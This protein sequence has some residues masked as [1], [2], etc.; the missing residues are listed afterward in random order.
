[1]KILFVSEYF[2]PKLAGGEVWSYELCKELIKK[3][4][5]ITVVTSK[6]DSNLKEEEITD[7]I[8]ILRIASTGRVIK[9]ILF[10]IKLYYLLN[11]LLKKERFDVIHTTSFIANI[12]ASWNARRYKV[13]SVTSV[14]S[15]F[16]KDWFKFENPFKASINFFMERIILKLDKSNVVHVPSKWLAGLVKKIKSNVKVIPNFI[17]K[18]NMNKLNET[19]MIKIKTELEIKPD[20]KLLIFIGSL[21]KIKNILNLVKIIEIPEGFH[22]LIVGEGPLKEKI[23]EVIKKKKI[24][25]KVILLKSKDHFSTM[26]YLQASSVLI[27]PSLSESFGLVVLEALYFNKIIISTDVGIVKELNGDKIIKIN[28]LEEINE[29]L[30][31]NIKKSKTEQFEETFLVKNVIEKFE[32]I[33]T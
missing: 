22:L 24:E 9:R 30:R 5:D 12:P 29:L 20:T 7:G 28:S 2:Y 10:M 13:H 19:E 8:K 27:N 18:E 33:Y 26:K 3:G 11:K 23:I 21:T 15:F 25:D 1:M 16:G 32:N 6:Y 17:V 14:H 4:H 31:N